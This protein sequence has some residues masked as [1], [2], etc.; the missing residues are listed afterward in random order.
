MGESLPPDLA[1][2]LDFLRR[3][4]RLKDVTRS[5]YTSGGRRE[6]VAAHTWRLALMAALLEER[7][8][9]MDFARLLKICLVHDLGEAIGGDV[10]APEQGAPGAKAEGERRDLLELAAPLPAALR[11]EIVALWDEYEGAATAEARLAKGLD[12]LETI[13]QH[14]QGAN[15]PDFDYRFNLGYGRRHTDGDPLLATLRRALDAETEQ[16]AVDAE[17]ASR[18]EPAPQAGS[19]ARSRPAIGGELGSE[20]DAESSSASRSQAG[21][22][23][24]ERVA[25]ASGNPVKAEACRLGFERAFPRRRFRVEGVA[26]DVD[27]PDQPMGDEETRRGARLRARE[28]ARLAPDAAFW[29][30]IEGG[31]APL[32]GDDRLFAFA[33]VV[34]R[35]SASRRRGESRTAAF[36]LPPAVAARVRAGEELGVADD[37]V[38]GRTDSK[39]AGGAVGLLT[40]G[41]MDRA[42]LYAG[43]VLLA[44]APFLR[45]EHFPVTE[46]EDTGA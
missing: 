21:E 6:S 36:E 26:V 14:T 13:L 12:K 16:R 33:W 18:S 2:V 41:A 44:L 1:G 43:A 7:L 3:A 19:A 9:E 42:E 17:S 31:V 29:V 4:E 46:A 28:A 45:P 15:P 35:E 27:V 37:Q 25:V 34:V 20:P 23:S 5:G 10:P 39:R 11:D 22:A 8:P 30:G 38:F 40:R 32:T 24:R